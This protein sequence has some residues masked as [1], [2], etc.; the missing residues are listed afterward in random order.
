ML[1]N[2]YESCPPKRIALIKPS[3]LGDIVHSLPVVTALRR[4]FPQ[5]RITWVVNKAY[6]PLLCGHPDLDATLAFPRRAIS[7]QKPQSLLIFCRFLREMRCQHFDLVIDLQGLLRTGLMTFATGARRRVGLASAREGARWFYTDI[8]VDNQQPYRHAVDRYWLVADALGAGRFAKE[9]RF[10]DFPSELTRFSSILAG[11]S[12]PWMVLAPGARW[13]TKRWPIAHFAELIH[14]ARCCFGG[15]VIVVGSSEDKHL[16]NCFADGYSGNSLLDLTGKTTIPE[17]VCVLKLADVVVAN[18]SGPL[19][20]AAA[21]GRPVV[22]PFTCTQIQRTGPY[23]WFDSAVES[24]VP[25]QGSCIKRC[26]RMDCM[27]ELTADRLWPVLRRHL[28]DW[29]RKATPA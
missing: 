6:E 1:T 24:S 2:S 3:A 22:A 10:P 25:C 29:E 8:V 27:V 20:I 7:W 13:Q 5:A 11:L 9:F 18:D 21:L 16:A 19:H 23:G 15:S 14:R 12:R 17:L 4:R 28:A 26:S